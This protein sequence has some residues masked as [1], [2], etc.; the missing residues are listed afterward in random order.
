M[1]MTTDEYPGTSC[2]P[3]ETRFG[4]LQSVEATLPGRLLSGRRL[5][6]SGESPGSLEVRDA[7]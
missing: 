2:R 5:I 3:L 4:C 7:T 1:A 6:G